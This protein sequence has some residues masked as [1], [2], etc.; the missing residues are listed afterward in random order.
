MIDEFV[1]RAY[2]MREW[3]GPDVEMDTQ[4]WFDVKEFV[5]DTYS[6]TEAQRFNAFLVVGSEKALLIDSAL[7]IGDIKGLAE[8]ITDKPL[9]LIQTHTHWDHLGGVAR[10]DRVGV[11]PLE[12]DAVMKGV[13]RSQT[14][15]F[16]RG[17]D[18]SLRPFPEG[19]DPEAYRIQPG[20][21][22][23]PLQEGD[24]IDLGGRRLTVYYTPGHSPGGISL[25]EDKEGVLFSGDMVK[26]LQPLFVHFKGCKL[27]D[28]VDSMERLASLS[29]RIKWIVSGHTPPFDDPSILNEMTDG[30]KAAI[31]GESQKR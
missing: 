25:L 14:D 9:E 17:Y 18:T 26:P 15:A 22:T 3:V 10:F 2:L 24:L 13:D 23:Y 8:I 6:I 29:T 12:A 20:K 1:E 27:E 19:F 31:L 16:I 4:N 11:H 30:L 28:Y 21:E 5:P 7:G